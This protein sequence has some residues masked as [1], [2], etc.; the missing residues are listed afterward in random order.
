MKE[1]IQRYNEFERNQVNPVKE[2]LDNIEFY[3]FTVMET[4]GNQISSEN[5]I[6]EIAE[7]RMPLI[8]MK[9]SELNIESD[10]N[11]RLISR[12]P[13]LEKLSEQHKIMLN[14]IQQSRSEL[15][16]KNDEDKKAGQMQ[17][18]EISKSHEQLSALVNEVYFFYKYTIICIY[19]FLNE[20]LFIDI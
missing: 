7:K 11:K 15:E 12:S 8:K 16:A 19:L 3:L 1:E 13:T 9:I 6:K 14:T 17:I 10:T 20:N 2:E 4:S 5:T 18:N